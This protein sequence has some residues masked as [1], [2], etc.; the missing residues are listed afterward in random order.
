MPR[1]PNKIY[2]HE[3]RRERVWE[4]LDATPAGAE[5]T[6]RQLW[7]RGLVGASFPTTQAVLREAVRIGAVECVG[8]DATQGAPKRYRRR[9]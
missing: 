8:W 4:A 9:S 2:R 7:D 3:R 6:L 1:D 5:F